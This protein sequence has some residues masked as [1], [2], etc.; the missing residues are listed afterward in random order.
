MSAVCS[1]ACSAASRFARWLLSWRGAFHCP[2][3]GLE[4]NRV[5]REFQRRPRLARENGF[6]LRAGAVVDIELERAQQRVRTFA[7]RRRAGEKCAARREGVEYVAVEKRQRVIV[8][9]L[10]EAR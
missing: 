7:A 10:A 6:D 9:K 5:V 4:A 1:T 2:H 8:E 3:E